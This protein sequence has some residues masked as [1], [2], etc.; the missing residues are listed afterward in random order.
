M[1]E[2]KRGSSRFE[3]PISRALAAGRTGEAFRWRDTHR[4]PMSPAW[5]ASPSPAVSRA[6]T[7]GASVSAETRRKVLEAA[8]VLGYRPSLIPGIMLKHRSRLI[9]MVVGGLYNP[10]YATVLEFFATRLQ[11]IGNQVLLI[12]VDSGFSLDEAIPQACRLP[13]RC[14]GQR[15]CGALAGRG[16]GARTPGN[17]GRLLQYPAE[18]RVGVLDLFRQS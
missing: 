10:F 18:E 9:A 13:G 1:H 4:Q 8:E 14:R 17:S 7:P 16:G 11:E 3:A 2:G 6:Y 15:P 12:H 5:P